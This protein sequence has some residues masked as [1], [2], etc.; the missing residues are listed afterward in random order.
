[1]KH[2]II[3]T[4]ASLLI[5]L[6]AS[7]QRFILDSVAINGHQRVFWMQLPETPVENAPLIMVC[8]GYGSTGNNHTW[9]KDIAAEKGA[10]LCIPKGLKDLRGKPSWNVGY[11]FQSGWKQNDVKELCKLAR[12]I[13]KKYGVSRQNCFLTGVSN[14]GE[15]C[16]L[17][18]Y[19]KQDVFKGFA[20]VAGLTMEWTYRTMEAPCPRPFLEIHGTED[21]TSEWTGD[22]QNKGGWGAYLSVPVAVGYWV[23]RNRCT[24]VQTDSLPGLRPNGRYTIKHYYSG[25]SADV[26]LY[27]VKGGTHSQ[28]ASDVNVGLLI[29]NFFE[30]LIVNEKR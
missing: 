18:A 14:G 30:K 10:V 28:L 22:L 11:P 7:G 29:W 21:R 9:M 4:L 3:I 12:H 20:S 16:Y 8:H 17:M 5:S 26:C 13:Q 6:Y 27:E 24:N 1:M 23:A 25:G 15:L 19:S 2:V